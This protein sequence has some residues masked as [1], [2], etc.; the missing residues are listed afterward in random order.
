MKPSTADPMPHGRAVWLLSWMVGLLGF[1]AA[2][3]SP[4]EQPMPVTRLLHDE[5]FAKTAQR[6]DS[7]SL[8][9]L[10][11]PMLDYAR[12]R[13]PEPSARKDLRQA[14]LHALYSEQGLRLHYA[15]QR[16]RNSAADARNPHR[17]SVKPPRN[18]ADSKLIGRTLGCSHARSHA[19]SRRSPSPRERP[20]SCIAGR[21]PTARSTSPRT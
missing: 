20:P 18:S 3:A 16:T 21:M 7:A 19:S 15:A 6:F 17:R 2:C 4:P 1:L 12:T 13:L 8:F 9:A 14:L 11:P 5:L 10:S